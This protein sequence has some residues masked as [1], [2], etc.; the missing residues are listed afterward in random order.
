MSSE[1]VTLFA[2][3]GPLAKAKQWH[4]QRA[5]E[6]TQDP[7]VGSPSRWVPLK[8]VSTP[9]QHSIPRRVMGYLSSRAI[10]QCASS[11]ASNTIMLQKIGLSQ[12]GKVAALAQQRFCCG[13]IDAQ[14]RP[15]GAGR[16]HPGGVPAARRVAGAARRKR[17]MVGSS[18]TSSI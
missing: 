13:V 8:P 1:C 2:P 4:A 18:S 14:A 16:A 12:E 11:S 15:R 6:G 10:C 5:P 3:G 9:S 17:G 7:A